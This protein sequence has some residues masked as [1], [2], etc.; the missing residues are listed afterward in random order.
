MVT[1]SII[2]KAIKALEKYLIFKND[3]RL[4]GETYELIMLM[5]SDRFLSDSKYSLVISAQLLEKQNQKTVITELLRIIKDNMDS[6][7]YNSISR[8]NIISSHDPIVKNLKFVF[9]FRQETF[10]ISD[11]PIGG[12]YIEFAYLAKSLVLD[13]LIA[14]NA[15]RAEILENG[16]VRDI[17]AGII[18]IDKNFRVFYYTGKGLRELFG[19]EMTSEEKTK[20]IN[21]LKQPEEF[22]IMHNY[23][24]FVSLDNIIKIL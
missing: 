24:S 1:V 4:T 19:Q 12:N 8:V 18:R 13:K 23:V 9:G 7:E 15:I 20:A 14:G 11:Y 3:F 17:A 2:H 21:L 5:P 16:Q 6:E 10:E 22:L